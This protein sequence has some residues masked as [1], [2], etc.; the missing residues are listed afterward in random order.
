MKETAI[1]LAKSI[2]CDHPN[3]LADENC[4]ICR[5]IELNEYPDFI[6]YDG[7]EGSVKKGD[8]SSLISLFSRTSLEVKGTMVYV[9]NQIE[10]MTVDAANSLLKFLEE[11]PTNTYAILTCQNE[12]KVLPTILSRCEKLR[13]LL[14][15]RKEVIDEAVA[16]NVPQEDAELLS[17]FIND[18]QL[19]ADKAETDEYKAAKGATMA[20]L[21]GLAKSKRY[22]RFV[23]ETEVTPAVKSKQ[24]LRLFFD[25]LVLML[26]D[27][28]SIKRGSPF[29][30]TSYATILTALSEKLANLE[31]TI[32]S[33]MTMRREIE[34]NINS[35]LLLT[36][37]V[38]VIAEE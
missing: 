5:R 11:P 35:G 38:N 7:E 8:V 19:L 18:G 21:E 32:L 37:L 22:A 1:Y 25:M 23:I 14:A 29:Y 20:F 10:N 12:T 9:I 34:M 13:L 26:E 3:P 4:L 16:L 24:T 27:A 31:N 30:L 15:S 33:V 17:H 36:H 28:L 6:F 2:L